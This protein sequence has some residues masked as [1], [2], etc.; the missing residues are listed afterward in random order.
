[1]RKA[2]LDDAIVGGEHHADALGGKRRDRREPRRERVD[3]EEGDRRQDDRPVPVELALELVRRRVLLV[4]AA[5][6][7][8][9]VELRERGEGEV[10]GVA[11]QR[12]R[13]QVRHELRL[14]EVPRHQARRRVDPVLVVARQVVPLRRHLL[15]PPPL[16]ILLLLRLDALGRELLEG[17]RRL[18]HRQWAEVAR[19]QAHRRRQ[20]KI[21]SSSDG[22]FLEVAEDEVMS[23]E[24]VKKRLE[25]SENAHS[26]VQSSRRRGPSAAPSAP[27]LGLRFRCRR[28]AVNS[29]RN[30]ATPP[31]QTMNPSCRPS[32]PPRA[33]GVI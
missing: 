4:D 33:A 2:H 22:F 18:G 6:L 30:D 14:A 3:E 19:C 21:R 5:R 28:A 7:G 24:T 29:T 23:P 20:E 12:A 27:R 15:R 9:A 26:S 8:D 11:Q 17:G 16:D 31:A 10:D 13:H 1:M 25:F 32:E